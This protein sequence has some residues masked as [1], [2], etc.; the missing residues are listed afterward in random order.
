MADDPNEDSWLYGSSNP[1]PPE[2]ENQN[3]TA[4]LENENE[5]AA[6]EKYSPAVDKESE[7]KTVSLSVEF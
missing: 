5:N 6:E 1:E 4:N 2:D 7:N 3:D